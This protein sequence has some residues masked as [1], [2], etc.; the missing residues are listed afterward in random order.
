MRIDIQ[1]PRELSITLLLFSGNF[2]CIHNAP[3]KPAGVLHQN[4][5]NC[6]FVY[7][8]LVSHNLFSFLLVACQ[9][10][11]QQIVQ[12][13][14]LL[15]LGLSS[16]GTAASIGSSLF[17]RL[18]FLGLGGY[19]SLKRSGIVGIALLGLSFLQQPKKEMRTI[20]F[21]HCGNHTTKHH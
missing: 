1:F 16:H 8:S 10:S 15:W 6:C 11:A 13:V 3:P 20:V 7:P 5:A 2:Q 18:L 9:T 21:Y 19:L 17:F 14:L 12:V 4:Q